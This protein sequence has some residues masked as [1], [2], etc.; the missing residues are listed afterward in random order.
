MLHTKNGWMNQSAMKIWLESVLIPYVNGNPALLLMDS[1]ESHKSQEILDFLKLHQN[2]HLGIIVGGSTS[3]AR[4]LDVKLNRS[5]K[6]VCRQKSIV[7]TNAM[8]KALNEIEERT[9]PKHSEKILKGII[10]LL[11]V[12]KCFSKSS[13]DNLSKRL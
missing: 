6:N 3:Y 13:D 5:F 7:Y 9:K 1:Y 2:I 8:L 4:P 11:L 12:F 10:L